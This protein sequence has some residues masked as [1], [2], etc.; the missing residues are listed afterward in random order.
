MWDFVKRGRT[1]TRPSFVQG[2]AQRQEEMK[3][4]S[5]AVV[6][7]QSFLDLLRFS[8]GRVEIH[9]NVFKLSRYHLR[10][11]PPFRKNH[12]KSRREKRRTDCLHLGSS[13]IITLCRCQC[14]GET[15]DESLFVARFDCDSRARPTESVGG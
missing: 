11:P 12:N 15:G 7:H 10:H 8:H 1:R 2:W 9:T 6:Y 3:R 4:A 14:V 5:C 13:G